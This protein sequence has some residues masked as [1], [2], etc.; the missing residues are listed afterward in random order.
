MID[1]SLIKKGQTVTVALS[2]GL[3]SVC[4]LH[5]LTT[6]SK[7]CGFSVNATHVNHNIR[8]GACD[9][10]QTFCENLCKSLGVT[11]KVFSVDAISYS[12]Q[13]HLSLEQGARALRYDC[14]NTLIA[15]GFCDL[16]ATAHHQEDNFETVLL[17]LF[18]GAG[19]K[20][21]S[22][23]KARYN[24]VIRPILSFS[25]QQLVDYANKNS[26]SFVT[27][28]SN[29]DQTYTRNYIRHSV[30][31]TITKHFPEAVKSVNRSATVFAEEDAFLDELATAQLTK[32]G[33]RIY[34]STSCAKPLLRRAVIIALG[35]LGVT[36]D[37]EMANVQSVLNLLETQSGKVATLPKNVVAVKE[38]DN[39]VFFINSD[40]DAPTEY[41]YKKGEFP[42]K[43]KTAVI[44]NGTLEDMKTSL[45]FD[46][47]KI[48]PSAKIRLRKDGDVFEKFGGG[49][50]KLKEFFIDKKIPLS[51]RDDYPV[52]AQGN[53]VY[54]IIGL[55]I[56]NSVKV[57]E[58]TKRIYKAYLK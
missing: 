22:G 13:N 50:K 8:K 26:L 3:D 24:S 19:L 28:E 48:P 33:E 16:V 37:Y 57:T 54:V 9:N 35:M 49:T 12:K 56:S 42:F 29:F 51:S 11:L 44:S 52:I 20:G 46:G 5:M 21:I 36:K 25:K 18:R 7:E 53:K 6:H 2:G 1:L 17:H 23:I 45:V 39:L 55:E 43:N 27:D 38:Y 15:E 4:L 58:K 47:A 14:F 10:D 41:I 31:P 40:E 30:T 32:K 34:L